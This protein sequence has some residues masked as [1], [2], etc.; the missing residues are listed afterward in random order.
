MDL[1]QYS[2]DRIDND[3]V[4]PQY[5]VLQEASKTHCLQNKTVLLLSRLQ[6]F[7]RNNTTTL[8]F[9]FSSWNCTTN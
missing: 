2:I 6:C 4:V 1:L 8:F 7:Q 3:G 9:G 5:Q